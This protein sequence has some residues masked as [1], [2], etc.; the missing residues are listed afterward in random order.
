MVA[1]E[2]KPRDHGWVPSAGCVESNDLSLSLL[3]W[4]PPYLQVPAVWAPT[5]DLWGRAWGGNSVLLL[6]SLAAREAGGFPS[7]P[8]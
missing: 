6:A 2:L 1:T 4:F 7:S 8:I 5:G 3:G